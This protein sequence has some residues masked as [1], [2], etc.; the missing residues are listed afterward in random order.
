MVGDRKY[1]KTDSPAPPSSARA[2]AVCTVRD[3][4]CSCR[5]PK[6]WDMITVAPEE[7]PT[8][9]PTIRLIRLP[10]E[11]PTAASACLPTYLPTIMASAV[12]YSCWKKV[13][14]RM[15]KKKISSCCQITP[16]TMP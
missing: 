8:K 10:V 4:S 16:S 5:A 12:L 13:P 2:T 14:S 9:K 1:P 3:T 11:P 15:G 7:R 6:N